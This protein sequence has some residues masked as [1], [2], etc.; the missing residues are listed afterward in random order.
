MSG[1]STE[2]GNPQIVAV[3]VDTLRKP[4]QNAT[5]VI[6]SV[7]L[8]S[9]SS[10]QPVGPETTAIG[11]TN[12]TGTCSFDSIPNGLYALFASDSGRARAAM[13]A[14]IALSGN[15]PATSAY[16]DTLVL[17]AT[18]SIK[19]VVTRNGVP[20]IIQNAQLKDG[21]IQVKMAEID[22]FTITGPD[23][24]YSFVNLPA[25]VYSIYYYAS[26]GFYT[27]KRQDIVVATGMETIA[28]TV[29]L[30]PVPRL[31]PPTGLKA[32]YDTAAGIVTLSWQ[33]VTYADL[34][35]YEVD[36]I[37]ISTPNIRSFIAVDTTAMDTLG[38][39]ATGDTIDYVVRS[40]D[41]SFIRSQNS[42][43]VEIVR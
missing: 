21:F 28:D 39:I 38:G 36:R 13:S 1:P 18:G 20:G 37:D 23:G 26:D 9:D 2:Q 3:V 19:G 11:K 41:N 32:I 14:K 10:L 31:L 40:F 27:S 16:S 15:R 33:K 12:G 7:P 17:G 35:W 6:Y 34:R 25:G 8:N 4:V 22:R 29:K 24:K 5:V 30:K 42:T 43:P